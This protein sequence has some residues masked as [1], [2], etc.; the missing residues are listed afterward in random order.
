MDGLH[1]TRIIK[2]SA[3]FFLLNPTRSKIIHRG[4]MHPK[5]SGNVSKIRILLLVETLFWLF[6][7]PEFVKVPHFLIL[8]KCQE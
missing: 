1:A 8:E 4:S 2:R 3:D 7:R 6:Y 5:M